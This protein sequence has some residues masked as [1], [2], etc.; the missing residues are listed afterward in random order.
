MATRTIAGAPLDHLPVLMDI[1]RDDHPFVVIQK[2]AQVG[3]SELLV[4]I[5]LHDAITGRAD[6]G[7]VIAFMPTQNMMDDFAQGRIDRAI[8]DSPYLRSQLQPEPPR[9]KGADNKRL[10]LIGRGALYLRGSDSRRQIAGVD[11]DLV[12]LDEYDEMDVGVLDLARK[13]LASSL[14]G[15]LIVSSTPRLPESGVNELFLRSDQRRYFIPCPRCGLEQTLTWP[16][17]VDLERAF[18]ACRDCRSQMNVRTP[19]TWVPQAPGNEAIHG[20]HLGRLYSPRAK[21]PEMIEAST[22]RTPFAL[23]AFMNSD[24]GEAFVPPGG[25]ISVDVIDKCRD[26]YDLSDYAGQRCNMGVD[27]GL[28]LH[29]VIRQRQTPEDRRRKTFVPRLWF[30]GDVAGFG[31]LEG[32]MAQFK[33]RSVVVD[34]MPELHA[35]S[36]FGR[37]HPQSAWLAQYDRQQ[38]GHEQ[39]PG[40]CG[41]P[42]RLHVNRAEALDGMYQ[43]FRDG[44][45]R[46]PR[47]ARLLGGRIKGDGLGEYY[48]HLL[49]PK[50]TIEDDGDGNLRARWVHQNHDDHFAHA[51][52]YAMLAGTLQIGGRIVLSRR[53]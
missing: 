45:A 27:V 28:R 50:R 46:V 22:A 8:Q 23:R 9:R 2:A 21:I 33:V 37:R 25:G 13:R 6:R 16:E 10:K 34:A 40:G 42:N 4:S 29:V 11:A 26:E 1:A 49:V 43:R 35:A 47:D 15:Q 51:E 32:L 24:L 19:G 53:W 41:E 52:V 7:N 48:R 3:I 31:E 30:A 39:S 5:M 17:N 36:E 14:R 44:D 20:Y 12:V 18:V 38:P